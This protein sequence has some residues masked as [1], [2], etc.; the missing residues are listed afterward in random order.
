M[1]K[2]RR[3]ELA[4]RHW[5]GS[6]AVAVFFRQIPVKS[7]IDFN[8]ARLRKLFFRLSVLAEGREHLSSICANVHF[9]H[10]SISLLLPLSI[11]IANVLRNQ[12]RDNRHDTLGQAY[13]LINQIA[14]VRGKRSDEEGD[15]RVGGWRRRCSTSLGEL[16][17][18]RITTNMNIVHS[19]RRALI[20]LTPGI[21]RTFIL[22]PCG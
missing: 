11:M 21:N 2:R 10:L 19:L 13:H 15:D 20:I 4:M 7:A 9:L 12:M 8:S 16:S 6:L 1:D 14:T 17:E 5:L 22:Y 18:I 3:S